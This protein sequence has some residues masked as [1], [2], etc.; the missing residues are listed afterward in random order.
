MLIKLM[1]NFRLN[2]SVPWFTNIDGEPCIL[3][4][5]SVEDVSHFLLNYHNFRGNMNLFGQT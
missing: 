2:G 5:E 4:K 1:G 3:C